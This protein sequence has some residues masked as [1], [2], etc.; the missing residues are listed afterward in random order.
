RTG[1]VSATLATGITVVDDE[2]DVDLSVAGHDRSLVLRVAAAAAH[3]QY[4]ISR[5]S[6]IKLSATAPDDGERWDERTK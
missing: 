3:A 5:R 1:R 2:V 4:P 6:L